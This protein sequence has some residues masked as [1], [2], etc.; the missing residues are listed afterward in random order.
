LVA[1]VLVALV[2]VVLGLVSLAF[3]FGATPRLRAFIALST[4]PPSPRGG[5]SFF[6]VE[7]FA[8]DAARNLTGGLV[9]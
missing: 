5:A 3:T 8:A 6:A 2:L 9:A 4:P 1:L 7:V